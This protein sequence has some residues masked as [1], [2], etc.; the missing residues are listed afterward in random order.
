MEGSPPASFALRLLLLSVLPA[1]GWLRTATQELPLPPQ[2][3]QDNIRINV[4]TLKDDGEVSKEQVVLNITYESGQVYVND[5][6][7]N[8]GVTRISCQTLI[9]KNGNLENVEEK[10][11]FGIV[12]VRILV[13]EWPMTSGSSLQLIV[14]QE[15]VV[16][17]D[18]KQAQQKDVTEIDILVKNQAILRH[19]NYTLPLEESMLYSISRDSDILFTLP[20]LS[21]KEGVS[22]L[23]TTSQYLLRNVETTVDEDAFPGKLPETPL[24]AEPPSSYKV[25][26]QWMEKFRKDLC[27]FWSSVFPVF[28]MF[29]N[30][31][32]VG[33]IGALVV[34]TILKVLFPVCE[35]KGTL[36]LDKANVIPVTAI[37][38]FPDNPEKKRAENLEDKACV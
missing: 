6:P 9:V 2:A 35:Y 20:N 5:F 4:T 17:I 36:Q 16:E 37:N 30:V 10:E 8:S 18:G 29:L 32:V 38:L 11:Y 21:K 22:S 28:F 12:S 24:R 3:P 31:M 19:S 23:Q 33:I 34:I 7:V 13:H 25:M 27:R 14:I 1:A 15:E 26:C